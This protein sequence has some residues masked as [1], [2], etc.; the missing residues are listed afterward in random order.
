MNLGRKKRA[1]IVLDALSRVI[2]RPETELHFSDEYELIVAVI[3]SAQCTDARV[4][5]VTPEL[6][7]VWSTFKSL[8]TAAPEDVAKVVA[9]ISYPNNKAKH[10]VG[11]AA[12]VMSDYHG[13][14]PEDQISLMK[15]PGVGRK[16]AQVVSS[17]AFGD[18]NALPVDT[19]VYRVA[20]RIGL[21]QQANTPLKVEMGLKRVIPQAEWGRAHHLLI[22]HGRY[23]CTARNP[24]C[25]ACVLRNVCKYYEALQRLPDPIDGLNPAKGKY[26]CATRQLYFDDP[27]SRTDRAGISQIACPKCDSMNVYIS[28]TG[29]TTKTVQDFRIE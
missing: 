3:L 13:K 17:V 1:R 8:S 28:K 20:N 27:I 22:L 16:T 14:L 26:Y 11:M 10:L 29:L 6:F 18:Q 19:H 15:L 4:N 23:T 2:S 12:K 7:K 25:D 9:S 21:V 5:L 24:D